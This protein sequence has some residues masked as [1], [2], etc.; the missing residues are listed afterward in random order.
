MVKSMKRCLH[1]SIRRRKFDLDEL[2]MLI[3]EVEAIVN[4]R[5]LSHIS[6]EDAE[7]PVTPSH[8]IYGRRLLNLPDGH[9][10]EDLEDDFLEH[11]VLI[12]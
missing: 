8:L 12:K 1:K 6:T 11:S 10:H 3:I 9:Y 7:E 5:S 4:S 2:H